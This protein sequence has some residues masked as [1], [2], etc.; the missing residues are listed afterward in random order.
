M[1]E[2]DYKI[3]KTDDEWP[4]PQQF[5][6]IGKKWYRSKTIVGLGLPLATLGLAILALPEFKAFVASL[7][8]EYI[9]L[10][11]LAVSVATVVLRH[12]TTGPVEWK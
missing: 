10:A 4:N 9:G 6:L 2:S 11:T 12:V 8:P 1:T 3:N 7:P 5:S